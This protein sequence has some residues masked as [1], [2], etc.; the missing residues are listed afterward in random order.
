MVEGK[1]G[2]K[3]GNQLPGGTPRHTHTLPHVAQP[4]EKDPAAGSSHPTPTFRPVPEIV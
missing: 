2:I 4:H 1:S 3:K